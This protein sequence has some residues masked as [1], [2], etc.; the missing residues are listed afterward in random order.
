MSGDFSRY[1]LYVY[2][3]KPNLYQSLDQ[4]LTPTQKFETSTE[5][6]G[7][8][9]NTQVTSR[10]ERVNNVQEKRS[11]E[12]KDNVDMSPE[13]KTMQPVSLSQLL[14]EHS[15][16]E[17]QSKST[18]SSTKEAQEPTFIVL[19]DLRTSESSSS[20]SSPL[21]NQKTSPLNSE[22]PTI[23]EQ[24]INEIEND[25]KNNDDGKDDDDEARVITAFKQ[26]RTDFQKEDLG[27]QRGRKRKRS[28]SDDEEAMPGK[29]MSTALVHQPKDGCQM[30]LY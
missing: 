3:E 7:M 19:D 9:L 4:S 29:S 8:D 11:S 15:T 16:P 6:I 28:L 5:S 26:S 23:D 20:S 22:F 13:Y 1:F 30:T 10:L 24:N 14:A 27:T 2:K 12:D 18:D 21:S 17:K 25:D